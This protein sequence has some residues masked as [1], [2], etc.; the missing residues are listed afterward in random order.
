[1][2]AQAFAKGPALIAY[3]TL[4]DGGLDYSLSAAL[5]LAQGGID[6]LE[7]GLPFS[8]PIADGPVIQKAMERSLQSGTKSEDLIPFLQAFRQ[9]SQVPIVIFSYFN[10][11]LAA[12]SS[13]LERAHATGANG[14]LIVDAPFELIPETPLDPILVVSP[15][16]P[17]DRLKKI[18]ERSRGF[19]YYACQKGTTGMRGTLPPHTSSIV[20]QI[21]QQSSLPVA[22]GFGIGKKETAKEA[23]QI[24]DGVVIG[25][26]F[27]EAMGR[28][29]S[30]EELIELLK[31]IDPRSYL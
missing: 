18:A 4:G 10:P 22:I 15:S 23:L 31:T 19:I 7:I 5:A 20:S 2:I 6:L 9:K 29:A 16:T 27:V 21:K 8:D 17:P 30:S 1:M 3:L 26:Y 28:K 14:L 13:F 11:L 12:G 24:A 25:S